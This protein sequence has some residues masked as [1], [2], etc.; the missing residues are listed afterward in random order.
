MAAGLVD[1]GVEANRDATRMMS[2]LFPTGLDFLIIWI[3]LM[4]MG[5]G[6][7]LV[8]YVHVSSS[9]AFF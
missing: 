8:A 4:R 1:L 3:T 6:V 5:Y 9:P 2:I 7:V